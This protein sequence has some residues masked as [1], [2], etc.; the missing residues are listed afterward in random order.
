MMNLNL[1]R[2][3]SSWENDFHRTSINGF[4]NKYALAYVDQHLWQL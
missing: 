4:F 1:L 3:I 2:I